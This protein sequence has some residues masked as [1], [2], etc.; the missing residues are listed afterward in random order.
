MQDRTWSI[1]ENTLESDIYETACSQ[2][3][4]PSAEQLHAL[5][6]ELGCRFPEEFILH[7]SGRFG[8]LYV[9]VKEDL[10]P[11]AKEG[12][13][14]AFWEFLFGLCTFSVAPQIPDFM[15][16]RLTTAAFKAETGLD[17]VP[18]MRVLGDPSRYCF[19]AEGNIVLWSSG[20]NEFAP[21]ETGFFDLLEEELRA[22]RE[23]KDRKLAQ[24]QQ[25]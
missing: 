19:D 10:W 9:A 11:R 21:V 22:L 1:L 25:A 13:V 23:R 4:A 2:G 24:R 5:A 18:F 3:D 15:N 16:L 20:S 17:L 8:G 7:S 6:Q 12:D 14:A